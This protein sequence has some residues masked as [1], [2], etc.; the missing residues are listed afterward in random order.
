MRPAT[1][2]S[3]VV[4]NYGVT[5]TRRGGTLFMSIPYPDAA[6]WALVAHGNYTPGRASRLLATIIRT[7]EETAHC[8]VEQALRHW[9]DEGLITVAT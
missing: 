7:D 5:V 9:L 6:L 3:W 2:V 1:G 8:T 4:E